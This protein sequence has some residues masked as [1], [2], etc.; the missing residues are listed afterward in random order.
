[1]W[2]TVR[3]AL[4]TAAS[5]GLDVPSA[6]SAYPEPV[7]ELRRCPICERSSE[8]Q[9]HTEATSATHHPVAKPRDRAKEAGA[10]TAVRRGILHRVVRTGTPAGACRLVPFQ[11]PEFI[12]RGLPV[13]ESRPRI[14]R[15]TCFHVRC[16]GGAT[17]VCRCRI[18][19][20]ETAARVWQRNKHVSCFARP[21]S[22]ARAVG[23][24][25]CSRANA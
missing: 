21:C 4:G 2:R 22:R 10:A 12:S 6:M 24:R 14:G 19:A 1:M 11:F 13:H 3:P 7:V 18:S 23:C 15:R 9:Q 25:E 8:L 16:R 5:A 17:S 20:C